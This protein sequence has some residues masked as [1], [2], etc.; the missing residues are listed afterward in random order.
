MLSGLHA[1]L[2]RDYPITV[3]SGHSLAEIIM[4][5][6]EIHHPGITEIDMMVVLFKEGLNKV[7]PQLE[8]L[9]ESDT[10]LINSDLLPVKT[11][12]KIIPLDLRSTGKK[13]GLLSLMTLADIL[14]TKMMWSDTM[15]KWSKHN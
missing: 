2:R 13:P 6:N 11:K 4:S 12:A 7:L 14:R 3:K 15:K 8:S 1:T 9:T 5:P 10:L